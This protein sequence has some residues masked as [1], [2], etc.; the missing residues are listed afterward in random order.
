MQIFRELFKWREVDEIS[1]ETLHELVSL[2][3]I[4]LSLEKIQFN[5]SWSKIKKYEIMTIEGQ[6]LFFLKRMWEFG[7]IKE[8]IGLELGRLFHP[9]LTIDHYVFGTYK[10]GF[11]R[12]L[13]PYVMTSWVPGTPMDKKEAIKYAFELGRQY[14]L[15]R[16]LCLY[17]CHPR[18]YFIQ[19]DGTIRRIDFGLA[20]S[21]FNKA[22]EGFADIWPKELFESTEFH[23]GIKLENQMIHMRFEV[24]EQDIWKLINRIAQLQID[25]FIDFEGSRFKAQL[26]QYWKRENIID[27]RNRLTSRYSFLHSPIQISSEK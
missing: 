12:K 4:Q 1:K 22:Y 6:K 8:I 15:G 5:V 3:G 7:S 25:D 17:D 11:F 21:K 16:W 14:E 19:Q 27:E 2:L 10:E 26:L 9:E 13:N 23:R 18:H 24:I 20:F